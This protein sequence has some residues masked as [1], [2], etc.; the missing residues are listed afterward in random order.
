[1]RNH[2]Q[3]P[4]GTTPLLEVNYSSQSKEKVN[5]AKPSKNV[6][7]FKKEKKNKHK[8][9]KS[10]EQSSGKGKKSFKCHRCGGANHIVKKCKIPN[11]WSTCTRNLSKRL[12]KLKNRM[13]LTSTLY[14]MRLRL[15]ASAV[16][17]LQSQVRRTMTTLTGRT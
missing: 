8:K 17:K 15:R 3:R 4:L 12:E 5:D 10:K 6:D 14:P 9:N 1:M 7:K 11:T 2:H 16:M 13:K